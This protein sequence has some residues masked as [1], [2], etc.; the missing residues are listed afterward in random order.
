MKISSV[1]VFT[2]AAI[3]VGLFV[4]YYPPIDN[5][6]E[7]WGLVGVFIGSAIT[8]LF[9]DPPNDPPSPPPAPV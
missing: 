2:V 9:K 4:S 1:E 8:K 6:K 7:I 3:A 5:S